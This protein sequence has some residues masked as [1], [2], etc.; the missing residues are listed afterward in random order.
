MEDHGTTVSPPYYVYDG[1]MLFLWTSDKRDTE[2]M[3]VIPQL[4]GK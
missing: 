2:G 1:E 3:A 4:Y